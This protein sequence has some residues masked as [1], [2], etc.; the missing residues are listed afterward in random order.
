MPLN[1]ILWKTKNFQTWNKKCL[2]CVILGF[3]YEIL[4]PYLKSAPL[5]Q[6][7]CKAL[8][9]D[10]NLSIWDKNILDVF[11]L[12]FLKGSYNW[13]QYPQTCEKAS[14]ARQ[15]VSILELKMPYLCNF[16]LKV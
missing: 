13:N 15:K 11:R 12:K 7:K 5:N 4:L 9:K 16:G 8:R 6:S 14:R 3:K 10:K 1:N 2:I